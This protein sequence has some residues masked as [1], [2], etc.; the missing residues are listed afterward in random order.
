MVNFISEINKVVVLFL[1]LHLV[2][3]FR[4]GRLRFDLS[5]G[6]D[7]LLLLIFSLFFGLFL[8]L[9]LLKGCLYL[10]RGPVVVFL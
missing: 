1:L 6:L 3:L 5:H 8:F 10:F 7:G 2:I 4:S 9:N